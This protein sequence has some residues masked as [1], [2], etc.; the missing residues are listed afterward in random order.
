[1]LVL[2]ESIQVLEQEI[3]IGE[4]AIGVFPKRQVHVDHFPVGYH[5]FDFAD[6]LLCLGQRR[7]SCVVRRFLVGDRDDV[8]VG[9]L[10]DA[11]IVE[12][13]PVHLLEAG[14]L[15]FQ[16]GAVLV[17][18]LARSHLGQWTDM[19]VQPDRR[20]QRNTVPSTEDIDVLGQH[21][22]HRQEI[23]LVVEHDGVLELGLDP[24]RLVGAH[25]GRSQGEGDHHVCMTEVK[26]DRRDGTE[27]IVW[28]RKPFH[29]VEGR[30]D[31]EEAE[32]EAGGVG[33]RVLGLKVAEHL[34]D[35]GLEDR[36]AFGP[37]TGEFAFEPPRIRRGVFLAGVAEDAL[38][39]ASG[40]A[41]VEDVLALVFLENSVAVDALGDLDYVAMA[42]IDCIDIGHS[43]T[44]LVRRDRLLNWNQ[45]GSA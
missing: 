40:V 44:V 17:C 15:P 32:I 12:D 4:W 1:V 7:R 33:A 9:C 26:R 28:R 13:N 11:P 38:V 27:R 8:F 22:E 19:I 24:R 25:A 41:I 20:G 6:R 3:P 10:Q 45:Y 30:L 29:G 31:V 5:R 2:K 43:P 23:G 37:Q 39:R 35:I 14:V 34:L 36:L 16:Y 42:V 21:E 18:R